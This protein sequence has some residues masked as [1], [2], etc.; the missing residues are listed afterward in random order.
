[1]VVPYSR[2]P[3]ADERIEKREVVAAALFVFLSALT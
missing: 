1:M 2:Q 3:C